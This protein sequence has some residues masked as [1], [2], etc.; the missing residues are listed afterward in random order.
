MKG[1]RKSKQ[2]IIDIEAE[3]LLSSLAPDY[4]SP[5]CP[6][7]RSTNITIECPISIQKL[8][9]CI[10]SKDT[11]PGCDDIVSYSMI[12]NLHMSGKSIL[13][14]LYNNFLTH[15]FVPKQWRDICIIPIPKA[16]QN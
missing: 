11:S 6:D 9:K 12:K 7:I 15:S 8:E 2:H 10:K 13:L 14:S 16:R 3:K 4:V 1:F 5:P